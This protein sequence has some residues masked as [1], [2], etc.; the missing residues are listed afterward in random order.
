MATRYQVMQPGPRKQDKDLSEA[1]TIGGMA[2]G[3]AYG[4]LPGAGAGAGLG[5]AAANLLGAKTAGEGLGA[6]AAGLGSAAQMQQA[7]APQPE[8]YN[9]VASAYEKQSASYTNSPT[10]QLLAS[11]EALKTASPE[12]RAQ[13]EPPINAAL[14]ADAERRRNRGATASF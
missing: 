6:G 9:P 7:A 1:L 11:K 3:A 12:V 5:G 8:P 13:A 2:V 14:K 4:G 10:A